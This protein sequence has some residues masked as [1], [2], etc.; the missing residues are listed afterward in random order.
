MAYD[1]QSDHELWGETGL[2]P[3]HTYGGDQVR[4]RVR[5]Q[6]LWRPHQK[7]SVPVVPAVVF[8][9]V[10]FRQP[11][12]RDSAACWWCWSSAVRM[13]HLMLQLLL[14]LLLRVRAS[15]ASGGQGPAV[16]S[17][18]LVRR[19]AGWCETS[20]PEPGLSKWRKNSYSV[21]SLARGVGGCL[22][23]GQGPL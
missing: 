1:H 15:S 5:M 23:M 7:E 10:P 12:A 16:S 18:V 13:L 8:S 11:G 14:L 2:C 9:Q 4:I 6:D 17:C 21:G 22:E 3:V 19:G 20:C